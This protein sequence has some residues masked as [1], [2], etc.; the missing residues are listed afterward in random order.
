[1]LAG[2]KVLIENSL[3]NILEIISTLVRE[4]PSEVRQV[5]P[6]GTRTIFSRHMPG[7][8]R[9]YPETDIEN[10]SITPKLLK[11]EKEKIPELLDKKIERLK[12]EFNLD[13]NKIKNILNCFSEDEFK[14]LLSYK[15]KPTIIYSNIFDIPKEVKKRE[16]LEILDL[17]FN[18]VE[19]I[20]ELTSKG[21]LNKN[22]LYNLHT[23]LYKE[24]KD[25][26]DNLE[27]FAKDRGLLN[28][29]VD[30][31]ELENVVKKIVQENKDAPFGALM[32]LVMKE[33][34]GKVDG[35]KVSE[36]LKKYT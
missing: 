6:K 18:L 19:Q 36:T 4:V 27:S 35:K 5:D 24:K 33:L 9:M 7:A 3:K 16:G 25:N 11:Q 22:S 31:K 8:A 20:V 28:E 30:Q 26:I 21:K 34:D 10:V 14:K 1:M 12:G 13:E 29:E 32:G 2:K 15:I 17:D 23:L